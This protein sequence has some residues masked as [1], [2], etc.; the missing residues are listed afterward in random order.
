MYLLRKILF[1]SL[2][3][4]CFACGQTGSIFNKNE[5]KSYPENQQM[6][7]NSEM[8]SKDLIHKEAQKSNSYSIIIDIIRKGT[9]KKYSYQMVNGHFEAISYSLDKPPKTI[10]SL[11]LSADEVEKFEK[12]ISSFPIDELEH[13]YYNKTIKGSY[14]LLYN[15][16]IGNTQKEIYLYFY[17][18]N[19]LVELFKRLSAFIP[20]DDRFSYFGN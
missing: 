1:L 5:T 15:L 3:L 19:D 4:S 10:V 8:K 18:Q 9:Y 7:K 20:I 11:D 2:I 14:H 6:I 17:Q 16:K 12:Y 13:S